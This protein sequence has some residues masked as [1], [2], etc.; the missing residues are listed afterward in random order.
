MT[1]V[2]SQVPPFK[3]AFGIL[4]SVMSI[5]MSAPDL[6]AAEINAVNEVLQTS[7]LSIGPKIKAFE[8]T[9]ATYVGAA[10]GVGVNSGTSGLHLSVIAAG[11]EQRDMMITTPFS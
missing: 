2:G 10:Y 6:S 3:A 5:P 11:V 8:R 9:F 7:M 4:D 1:P